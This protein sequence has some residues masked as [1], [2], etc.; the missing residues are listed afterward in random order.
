MTYTADSCRAFLRSAWG[1]TACKAKRYT[2]CEIRTDVSNGLSMH[3]YEG[4]QLQPHITRQSRQWLS[5]KFS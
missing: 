3:Y 5:P 1:R 4:S 2:R